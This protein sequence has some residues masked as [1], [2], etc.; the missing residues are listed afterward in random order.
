MLSG[1]QLAWNVSD[2]ISCM[3]KYTIV[4]FKRYPNEIYVANKVYDE[5]STVQLFDIVILTNVYFF[6]QANVYFAHL[7]IKYLII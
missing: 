5:L 4:P 6:L 7:F 3:K 1:K 2:T